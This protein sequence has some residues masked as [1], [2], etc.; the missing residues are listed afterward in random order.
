MVNENL[1]SVSLTKNCGCGKIVVTFGER[2][3]GCDSMF[4]RFGKDGTCGNA[5]ASSIGKLA[6]LAL[7]G[8]TTLSKIADFLDEVQCQESVKEGD[9]ISCPHAISILIRKYLKKKGEQDGT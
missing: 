8:G 4:I 7:E 2:P 1:R 9:K 6:G 3:E 5:M